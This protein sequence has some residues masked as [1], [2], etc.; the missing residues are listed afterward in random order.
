MTAVANNTLIKF[1]RLRKLGAK[2]AITA[3][4]SKST[5]K[6]SRRIP[7]PTNLSLLLAA[8]ILAPLED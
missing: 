1:P 6:D 3:A 4:K 8:A 2:M 5:S 7:V